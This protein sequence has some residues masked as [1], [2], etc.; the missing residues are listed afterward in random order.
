MDGEET[1][2]LHARALRLA[3]QLGLHT[4]APTNVYSPREREVRNRTWL[5]CII[6][7]RYA[8]VIE[9]PY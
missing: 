3:I 9:L 5:S 8:P 4:Q 2:A 1:G 6:L 7:D